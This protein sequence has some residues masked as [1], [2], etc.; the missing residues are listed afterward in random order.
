[1]WTWAGLAALVAT[2]G[3]AAEK[4]REDRAALSVPA[5]TAGETLRDAVASPAPA[6]AAPPTA[7]LAGKPVPT[8]SFRTPERRHA[9]IDDALL[10]SR[11]RRARARRLA[12]P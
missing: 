8:M 6:N 1:M 2:I 11:R 7:G 9:E 4:V 5:L 10:A 12:A 3:V